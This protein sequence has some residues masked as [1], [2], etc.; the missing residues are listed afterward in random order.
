MTTYVRL[1]VAWPDP[2]I[3][4][5]FTGAPHLSLL[6]VRV[7]KSLPPN[8]GPT[9]Q[10]YDDSECAEKFKSRDLYTTITCYY[11]CN[12]SDKKIQQAIKQLQEEHPVGAYIS[13][14]AGDENPILEDFK[15][16]LAKLP[17]NDPSK[18]SCLGTVSAS[19]LKLAG[20]I[21]SFG[22]TAK[23]EEKKEISHS[24]NDASGKATHRCVI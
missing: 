13:T 2:A 14:V 15:Y 8:A 12:D 11:P 22:T 23:K 6:D 16:H 4:K 3:R 19:L 7:F 5:K 1:C 24:H 17:S 9:G 20:I 18:K 21:T 10:F